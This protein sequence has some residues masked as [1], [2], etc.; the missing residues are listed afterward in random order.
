MENLHIVA[1]R[2]SA[3][4]MAS[5]GAPGNKNP[6][7]VVNYA[8]YCLKIHGQYYHLTITA[9][10]PEEGK[11]PRYAQLYFLD[12]EEAVKYRI[13]F[14][15][16]QGCDK[17][18]MKELSCLMEESNDLVKTFKMMRQVEQELNPKGKK[19]VNITLSFS[20]DPKKDQR[21]YN[22]PQAN[23][24]AVDKPRLKEVID[25]MV[26]AKIPDEKKYPELNVKVLK[27]MIHGPCG[28]LNKRYPCTGEDGKCSKGYPKEFCK[29]TNANGFDCAAIEV[30]KGDGTKLIRIDEVNSYLNARYISTPEAMWRLNGYDLFMKSHTIIRLAVHLPN[31]QMVYFQEGKEEE[32]ANREIN[33]NT[34]LTAWFKLNQADE[35]ALQ[36]RYTDIPY[37]Y[38][39]DKKETKWKQRVNRGEKI[40]SRLYT[41]GI[42][43]TE[44]F[45]L[46][47]LLLHV[48]GAKNFEDI[49]TI[50][51]VRYET[52]KEAAIAKQL[53]ETDD[54]WEKTIEEAIESKMP[55][56]LRELFAYICI[57]GN[58]TNVPIIWNKYKEYMIEDY[59]KKNSENPEN[60]ALNHIQ[61][62]LKNNEVALTIP[63]DE[64]AKSNIR[65]NTEAAR[66]IINAKLIIWDEVSMTVGHALT[67][68]DKLLKELMR[69]EKPFGG[70]VVLFAGDFRQNLPVVP[71][72]NKAAIIESTMKY[73]SI[74]KNVREV[75]L[76]QNMRTANE[77]EFADWLIELGD[78]KR[79]FQQW[80]VDSYVKIEKDR[81]NWCKENQKHLRVEKHQGLID[82]LEKKWL[83]LMFILDV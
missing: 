44:R 59:V 46:R 20:K 73:N 5:M 10:R 27:H 4:A 57:Y 42:K 14:K 68:V 22:A 80:L 45:Y 79:L 23:E 56:E 61:E 82:Y 11:I 38:V 63:I 48:T 66:E 36:M 55:G 32:A 60:M 72:A 67:A 54:L 78:G 12:V 77:K 51:G 43:D 53:V 29:E 83:I 3:L 30:K 65:G 49:K 21:R 2:G 24:I 47:L 52:Y 40:I 76:T 41:V 8:P 70:K 17:E 81:I 6:I 50:N 28:D 71:H 7:D 18:L 9:M 35:N 37:H 62:I 75:K 16:N 25:K 58:I 64:G 1:K 13:N 26:W 74:W 39:Y 15:T 33:R 31:C 34:T 69:N 19:T